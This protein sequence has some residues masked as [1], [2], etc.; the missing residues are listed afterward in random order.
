MQLT[1]AGFAARKKMD[2][3]APGRHSAAMAIPDSG[4]VGFRLLIHGG[5]GDWEASE[6]TPEKQ[7]PYLE[8]LRAALRAGA[9]ILGSGGPAL[10]ATEAAVVVLEDSPLFNAGRGSVLN[11]TGRVEADAAIMDGRTLGAGSVGAVAA[12]PNPIRLARAVLEYSPHVLLTG[13]GALDFARARGLASADGET[14]ITP[15]RREQWVRVR[16]SAGLSLDH[17]SQ[18]ARPG[19]SGDDPGA[20]GTVGAVAID[21]AGTLAAATSTGGMV[22]KA[23][24][25]VGDS[26]IIGA[27]TYARN[28]ICAVSATGQGEYFM[29]AVVAHDLAARLRYGGADLATAARAALDEVARLGGRGGLIALDGQ[30]RA[31]LPFNTR[32]MFRGEI[33]AEAGPHVAIFPD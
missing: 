7:E 10:E 18:P 1:A 31:A 4:P 9:A 17:D 33:G 6:L 3:R 21:R 13:A 26:P 5:A 23:V 19:A 29:R 24:G 20:T 28:G 14:L 22:N 2:A 16:D 11:A 8:T 32:V 15:E 30:G 25:R 12:V 27:G